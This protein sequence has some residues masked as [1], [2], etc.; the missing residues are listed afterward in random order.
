MFRGFTYT[1]LH[2]LVGC[3][4][5]NNNTKNVSNLSKCKITPNKLFIGQIS[6]FN[7]M[8]LKIPSCPIIKELRFNSSDASQKIISELDLDPAAPEDDFLYVDV[9]FY[10][11]TLSDGTV[12]IYHVDKA[13]LTENSIFDYYS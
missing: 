7:G 10:G 6:Y 3:G 4:T 12:I 2:L 1:L 8:N 13:K 11:S 9:E 5:I